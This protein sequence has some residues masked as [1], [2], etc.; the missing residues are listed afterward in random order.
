M[1]FREFIKQLVRMYFVIYTG[2]MV[3]TVCFCSI[4]IPDVRLDVS[5]VAWMFLFA[6]FADLPGLVFYSKREL[7]AEKWRKRMG[8]HL[9][10]LEAVLLAA[11]RMY[12]MWCGLLQGICFGGI[13]LGVYALVM[14]VNYQL[15]NRVAEQLN[16][17]LQGKRT[18]ERSENS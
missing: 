1:N 6:L 12:E 14:F 9:L 4:F 18:R 10:L 11:G 16:E 17:K 13:I 15:D 8:L 3:G 5:F 7:S 2:S